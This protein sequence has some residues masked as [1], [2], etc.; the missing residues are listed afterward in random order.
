MPR[1][2]IISPV[3]VAET[4]DCVVIG[5]GVVGLA[6]ARA[7]ARAGREV[8]VLE[9]HG[10]IG[11]ET[12]SRNSEVIHAGIYYDP[13]SAKARLCVRGKQLLYEHCQTYGVPFRRCGKLIVATDRQQF[14]LLRDYQR[15]ALA[16]GAGELRWLEATEVEALEPAVRSVGGVFSP[17][18]GIIDS[19]A[20]M[21]SLLG[22][23]QAHGGV[24]AFHASVRSGR[25]DAGRVILETDELT[26][27]AALVVNAGGLHAPALALRL[28]HHPPGVVPPAFYA[29]GHYY[30]LAGAAPFRHLVYPV[31]EAGGLGVHVTLDLA[32]QARFGPDVVWIDRIDYRFDARN[33]QRAID[34]IRRYY[35]D[36]EPDRL[37]Q[38]YTGIR[39]KISGPDEPAADFQICGP[40]QHGIGGLIHLFGIESPGL[41]ASLA[42][43]EEVGAIAAQRAR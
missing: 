11:T 41:T 8:L 5:A 1:W 33:R 27:A 7:L 24:I 14:A 4:V 12:S 16:N 43:A 21:E 13:G 18:T 40:A 35:P 25:T 19:H 2:S 3:T 17:T 39:P 42:I 28:A 34:A 23:V 36:L 9:Q 31:A 30:T 32:G 20:L 26:L 38:G 22:D 15:R 37:E 10:Q 29:K 6:C